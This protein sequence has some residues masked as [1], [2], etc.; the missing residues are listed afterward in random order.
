MDYEDQPLDPERPFQ[1][2]F[3]AW[4]AEQER[5]SLP[6]ETCAIHGH[7]WAGKYDQRAPNA[8]RIT[9]L[10]DPVKRL[11][12]HYYYWKSV[13]EMPHSLH[14]YVRENDLSLL[15]FAQ[16]PQLQN[17][18]HNTFLR[19]RKLENFAFV[20]IQEHFVDDLQSLARQMNWPK[21]KRTPEQNRTV[22]EGYDVNAVDAG[23]LRKIRSLNEADL[24]LYE[25]ALQMRARRV[26]SAPLRVRFA[27]AWRAL[28]A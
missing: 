24:T 20:G 17:V 26:A 25:T 14:N 4:K 22:L 16:I 9:W 12:S 10:R 18:L 3:S 19:D 8:M 15:E 28:R 21:R 23:T 5:K 2:D 11:I 13:P 7:F 27:N 1:K 6:T